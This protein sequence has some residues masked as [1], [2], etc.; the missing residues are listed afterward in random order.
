MQ[1]QRAGFSQWRIFA[2]V[3]VVA[4][5]SVV[6]LVWG[7]RG[8]APSL[9]RLRMAS[10][11]N[12]WSVVRSE[13]RGYLRQ[14]SDDV[15]AIVL[16]AR[17]EAAEKKFDRALELL[18]QVPA[19]ST[20]SAE[21]RLRE[22]EVLRLS[23]R[24]VAAERSFRQAM[25]QA[26]ATVTPQRV[27]D[28]ARLGLIQLCAT[29]ARNDEARQLIWEL[30]RTSP[31]PVAVLELLGRLDVEGAD[32][33]ESIAELE[34]FLARDPD[35]FEARR[36]LAQHYLVLGRSREARSL[37]EQCVRSNRQSLPAWQNLF[38]CLTDIG[39]HAA[40]DE[41]IERPP[42]PARETAWYWF[43]RGI[44]AEHRGQLEA[45]EDAFR[46]A[47]LRDPFDQRTH[48]RLA[49]VLIEC[50]KDSSESEKHIGRSEQLN[51]ARGRLR[52]FYRQV[53]LSNQ[54]ATG[55]TSELCFQ[56]GTAYEALGILE[57]AEAWYRESL[58]RNPAN[59]EV[60]QALARLNGPRLKISDP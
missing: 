19:S 38:S 48:Y 11:A 59:A 28:A 17:A 43:F 41:S 58:K 26:A 53:I 21:A 51:I 24:G 29:E 4:G 16:V 45:A 6:W 32:P 9:D 27:S 7:R 33:H 12:D 46:S 39:D 47:L 14:H 54:R 56:M 3:S 52:E 30:Y 60:Q 20:W 1:S 13:G 5:L 36:A 18:S 35:D 34:K 37:A 2:T 44:A 49:R 10:G 50:G 15:E 22:G 31:Q 42:E 23:F 25:E 8:P 55:P 40:L 57:G